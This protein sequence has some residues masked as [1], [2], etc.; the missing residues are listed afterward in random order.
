M[1]MGVHVAPKNHL[2]EFGHQLISVQKML[3]NQ[4]T[5]AGY[6]LNF[7]HSDSDSAYWFQFLSIH[8]LDSKVVKKMK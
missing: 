8:S 3:K 6:C 1:A 7:I 5:R 2:F 4:W